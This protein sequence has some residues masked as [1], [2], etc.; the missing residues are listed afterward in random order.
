MQEH[1]M[2][3]I[4]IAFF[5]V[6]CLAAPTANAFEEEI[7][8]A[9]VSGRGGAGIA[10]AKG[11]EA[12]YYNPA[13]ETNSKDYI[14]DLSNLTTF[15]AGFYPLSIALFDSLTNPY[16]CT[17]IGF[18]FSNLD[19]GPFNED[20]YAMRLGVGIPFLE[21]MISIGAGFKYF[22]S[23]TPDAL[24]H[25]FGF[26]LGM[27][28]APTPLLKLGVVAHNL[29][30][31]HM[32]RYGQTVGFGL[33]L[34]FKFLLLESNYVL[35]YTIPNGLGGSKSE[36]SHEVSTGL[37]GSIAWFQGSVGY[38]YTEFKGEHWVTGGVGFISQSWELGLT[39]GQIVAIDSRYAP[40][41]SLGKS[42][43]LINLRLH[44]ASMMPG[45]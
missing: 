1:M 22:I 43:L 38:K 25:R 15:D 41:D 36:I 35:Y 7:V 33:A 40:A 37:T 5:I 31:Y 4:A 42:M 16:L 11:S 39:F 29:G 6:F 24:Y 2:K 30:Q 13:A 34:D 8:P 12:A 19:S 3:R 9:G 28:V 17:H 44:L 10:G 18:T 27:L 45:N 20:L 26:D 14:L 21:N 32:D 23:D